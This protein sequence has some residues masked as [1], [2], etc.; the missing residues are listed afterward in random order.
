MT[1]VWSRP[2]KARPMAGSEAS[3]SSR[4]RYIATWRGPTMRRVRLSPVSSSSVT[5]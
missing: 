2:P 5:W 1:V 3:V 4:L